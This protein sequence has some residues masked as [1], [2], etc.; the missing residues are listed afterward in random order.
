MAS[1]LDCML[2]QPSTIATSA[3]ATTASWAS[4]KP[5][6]T[7]RLLSISLIPVIA[8]AAPMATSA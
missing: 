3:A 7:F 8:L 6:R 5:V 4:I 1:A 2:L